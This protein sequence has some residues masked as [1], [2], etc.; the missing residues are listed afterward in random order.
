MSLQPYSLKDA[1]SLIEHLLPVQKISAESFKEQMAGSGKALTALGN[2]WKG[3][4]PL[5]LNKACILGCLL[6]YTDNGAKDLE[7]FDLLMGIAES[8]V[9]VRLG[10]IKP[11]IVAL[12]VPN[13]KTEKYFKIRKPVPSKYILS[14]D[15]NSIPDKTPFNIK[16]FPYEVVNENTCECKTLTPVIYWS[17]SLSHEEKLEAQGKALPYDTHK[18][19]ISDKKA[20]RPE[21]IDESKLYAHIWKRV[22]Q[23][24][25]TEA[26]SIQ[27]LVKELGIARFGHN[28]KVADTF[29]G[30]G[31]I[32]FEAARLGCDVYASDLN[33]IACMLT[34]GLR[35]EA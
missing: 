13:L 34:W 14:E 26:S 4:K 5:I 11:E 7:I 1:P 27:E 28:P 18:E 24:L 21:E 2:Y 15:M 31:Q 19:N 12:K 20:L 3:R 29:C 10:E 16:D 9:A 30:S 25:G 32:P 35:S 22:N 23:H 8:C 6:P 17:E 33:P